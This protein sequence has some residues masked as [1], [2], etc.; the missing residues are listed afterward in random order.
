MQQ[1]NSPELLNLLFTIFQKWPTNWQKTIQIP[2]YGFRM[3]VLWFSLP[4]VPLQ[5]MMGSSNIP[6]MLKKG[7][8][9]NHGEIL[10][11]FTAIFGLCLW[12]CPQATGPKRKNISS[13][14]SQTE[15][16][17]RKLSNEHSRTRISKR[18]IPSERS[19]P[20]S[21]KQHFSSVRSQAK[22]TR[23]SPPNESL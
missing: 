13:E 2:P 12:L 6:N 20:I 16:P 19:Q 17:S 3:I 10:G 15:D 21:P 14:S 1:N 9:K 4:L 5:E 22:V 23:G 7:S 11:T 18:I 8:E